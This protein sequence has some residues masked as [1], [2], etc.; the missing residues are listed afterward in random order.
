L[1]VSWKRGAALSFCLD[2]I[3]DGK[4]CHTF[5][6]IALKPPPLQSGILPVS[7]SANK[8]KKTKCQR[9]TREIVLPTASM[10]HV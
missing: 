3:P 9:Q 8:P 2:A 6:G 4:P 5:P 7:K 1:T 10:R